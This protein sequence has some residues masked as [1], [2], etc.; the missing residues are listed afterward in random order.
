[1]HADKPLSDI[2]RSRR[3]LIGAAGLFATT[4]SL[5][6]SLARSQNAFPVRPIRLIVPAGAGGNVD[7]VSRVVAQR[8][9]TVL[10]Q[11]IVIENKAGASGNIGLGV[12]ANSPPDGYTLGMAAAAMLTINPHLYGSMSFDPLKDLTPVTNVSTGAE[13]LVV[14][15][16]LG[17][18]TMDALI[19]L[20][21]RE[22]GKLNSGSAGRGSLT[23][24]SLEMLKVKA[25]VD[26]VH[27]PFKSAAESLNGVLSGTVHMMVDTISTSLPHIRSGKLIPLAVTSSKRIAELPDVPT[28]QEASVKD[29]VAE[30][31]MAVVGPAGM[32][33]PVVDAVHRAI[34]ESLS[35]PAVATRLKTLVNT[36]VGSAPA[37]LAAQIKSEWADWKEVI[38]RAGLKKN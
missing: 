33:A 30:A 7:L 22:P 8:A 18:R 16:E 25:G 27:V 6:C 19:A 38:A 21:K 15:P 12:V 5:W 37:E 24:M 14:R 1:M 29:Y 35:D 13:V 34:R 36:P 23:H 3:Q 2:R 11:P 20:A 10:G 28:F 32:K 26:I 17:V 31:W 9:S 4:T